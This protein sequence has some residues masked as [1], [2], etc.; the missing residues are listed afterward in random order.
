MLLSKQS[1]A[2]ASATTILGISTTATAAAESIACDTDRAIY[3]GEMSRKAKANSCPQSPVNSSHFSVNSPLCS[4]NVL[5][6]DGHQTPVSFMS[7]LHTMGNFIT[8]LIH[9]SPSRRLSLH[10]GAVAYCCT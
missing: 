4:P 3:F 10:R 1:L 9:I 6:D 8:R 5:T 2:D 7:R